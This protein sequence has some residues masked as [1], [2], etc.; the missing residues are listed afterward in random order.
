MA[1]KQT[2]SATLTALIVDD[3][4]LARDELAFL[5]K[6]F[7]EVEVVGTAG[8]GLA[9]VDLIEEN[10]PDIVFMDVQMPGLDGLDAVRTL[11]EKGADLPHFI[12]ATAHDQYAVDA[13][14]VNAVDYLLKPSTRRGW[15]SRSN[16]P[17]NSSRRPKLQTAWNSCWHRLK[18]VPTRARSCW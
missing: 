7:P 5:L 4:E 12:F 10:A 6:S 2:A 1:E 17:E 8:N 16:A 14:E 9:A 15:P 18:T 3:E 11:M 13:F